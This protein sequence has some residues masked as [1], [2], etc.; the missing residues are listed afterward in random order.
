[1]SR[2]GTVHIQFVIFFII[3]RRRKT[4]LLENDGSSLRCTEGIT[5]NIL[6]LDNT[7]VHL[8]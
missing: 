7:L 4:L 5:V 8:K 3:V 6:S 1:M 2:N